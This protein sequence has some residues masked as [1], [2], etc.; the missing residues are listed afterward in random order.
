VQTNIRV[1]KNPPSQRNQH[2]KGDIGQPVLFKYG[3][4]HRQGAKDG[5]LSKWLYGG[6]HLAFAKDEPEAIK[7]QPHTEQCN[8]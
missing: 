2:K 4:E 5:E 8:A 7:R 3:S 6:Q 1:V